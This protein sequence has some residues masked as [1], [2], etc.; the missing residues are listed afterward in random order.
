[1]GFLE[2]NVMKPL[3]MTLS[4]LTLVGFSCTALAQ[5]QFQVQPPAPM[6]APEQTQPQAQPSEPTPPVPVIVMPAPP[7]IVVETKVDLTTDNPGPQD[8]RAAQ[9]EAGAALQYARTEGC[10]T[11]PTREAQRECLKR[12][13]EEYNE[14]MAQLRRRN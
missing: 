10:R 3:A 12:A 6:Q 1:M 8:P 11:E 14:V 5:S 9:K 2:R 13:Q 4:A 7:P